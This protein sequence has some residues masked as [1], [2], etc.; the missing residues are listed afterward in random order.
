MISKTNFWIDGHDTP[1]LVSFSV[2]HPECPEVPKG[3]VRGDMVKLR[4]KL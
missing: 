4:S 3:T 2:D 1:V